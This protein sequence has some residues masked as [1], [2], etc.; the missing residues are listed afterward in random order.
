MV[1]ALDLT[2]EGW[3]F[4]AHCPC[5]RVVSLTRNLTPHCLSP[6][7]CI[8]GYRR[9]TAGGNPAMDWHSIQGGVAILSVALCYR[10]RDKLRPCEPRWLVC[11]FTLYLTYV[12]NFHWANPLAQF[13]IT[14]PDRW[15][16]R[17]K[18]HF[19]RVSPNLK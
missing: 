8:N 12:I 1:S 19:Y 13:R 7:K 4:D 17:K 5:H 6:P 9:H 16:K 15:M 3:W 2:S 18:T 14:H 10:N 11:A